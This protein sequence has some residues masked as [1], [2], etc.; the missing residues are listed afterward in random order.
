MVA[1][2]LCGTSLSQS[3]INIPEALTV[4]NS[5]LTPLNVSY[6]MTTGWTMAL[7]GAWLR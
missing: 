2:P 6:G 7:T 5:S 3:P 1:T 4:Y